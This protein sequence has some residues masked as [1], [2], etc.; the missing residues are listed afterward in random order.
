MPRQFAPEFRQR[1]LR[2]LEEALPEHETE[3]AAI[4]HVATKLGIGPETL[5]KWRRR[6]EIDSGQRPRVTSAEQAEIKQLKREIAELKRANEIL[7]T[8]SAFFA[9]EPGRP[10]TR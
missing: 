3:Y 5:R 9:A 4:R 1:A 6:S 8:A 10:T 2:M 7:K